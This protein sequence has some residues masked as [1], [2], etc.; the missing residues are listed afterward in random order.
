MDEENLDSHKLLLPSIY[1]ALVDLE[2]MRALNVL[3]TVVETIRVLRATAATK[4]RSE[5]SYIDI[6]NMDPTVFESPTKNAPP[7]EK[8]KHVR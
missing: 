1:L 5:D 3:L 8:R 6:G 4:E 2:D 7:S